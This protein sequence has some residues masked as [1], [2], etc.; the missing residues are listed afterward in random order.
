MAFESTALFPTQEL[1][2]TFMSK[3]RLLGITEIL[4]EFSG[5]GDSGNV[6][7]PRF[8]DA[9]DADITAQVATKDLE[10]PETVGNLVD[11]E[12]KTS[13]VL[14]LRSLT[15]IV[16]EMADYALEQSGLDW[17][18]NDGGQGDMRFTFTPAGMDVLLSVSVNTTTTEDSSYEY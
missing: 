8:Y 18:N 5:S 7:D 6:E 13:E 11:G 12:W 3:V 9:H 14:L 10:W 17:Y 15:N 1:R 16:A 4:V 2:D